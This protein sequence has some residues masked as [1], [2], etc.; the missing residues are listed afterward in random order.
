MNPKIAATLILVCV[1]SFACQHD[2]AKE[3]PSYSIEQFQST[4]SIFGS[5][6]SADERSILFT[7]NTSGV[8][9]A[10]RIDV[11]TGQTQ[12]LT[13]STSDRIYAIS[14]F[15]NDNRMLFQSDHGGNENWHLFVR[16]ENGDIQDVT[17]GDQLRALF[18]DWSYDGKSFFFGCNKRNPKFMDIYEMDITSM[19]PEMLY[20]NDAGYDFGAI[21]NNKE[22]IALTKTITRDN[23]D[24]Y[25]FN[26]LKGQ[27]Q[28]LTPHREEANY[29][30]AAFDPDS[31]FL[32]YRTNE[33]SEFLYLKR[34]EMATRQSEIVKQTNWDITLASVSHKGT[35]LVVGVNEDA[36]TKIEL[37][38]LS[39]NRQIE[40]PEFPNADITSILISKSERSMAFYLNGSRS[41][42][43][44]YL[45]DFQTN[46]YRRLT[47]SQNPEIDPENLVEAKIV[48]YP[49]FDGLE[50]PAILYKP[51]HI[52]DGA[53][54]PAVIWVHGGPGGQS[55]MGFNARMQYLANHGYVVLAVN[56]R[57]SSGYGKTFF[58]LDDL[59]HGEHDLN[60]CVWGKK[61]LISTGYVDANKVAIAGTSYGGYM[62]AAALA[63]LPEEF[64]AGVDIFGVTNWV[65]TLKSIPPW[66]EA[67]R[68]ALY[69]EMGNPAT[70]EDY[71]RRISPLFHADKITKPLIVLQ[72]ANDRR[73]LQTES[74]EIVEA[75]RKNGVPVEYFVFEDEGHGFRNKQNQNKAWKS[76]LNFL[77]EHV[78][79]KSAE[80]M[81]S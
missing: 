13:H 58:Q 3:V 46:N 28:H 34:Y 7:S 1:A 36:K 65:R 15:P 76:I 6:F 55:R 59:K 74:D 22:Y 8:F 2:G 47:N 48:R 30:P 81:Q 63:F 5:S 27:T 79:G 11:E 43:D 37:Y 19:T 51:H 77:D 60:D 64:A 67:F 18:Y 38:D 21:S 71:L 69:R 80:S 39:R 20:Q 4:N 70:D 50:I 49:S 66:W 24:I 33:N 45:Y 17:P 14:F 25:L 73:V 23:S 68:I 44:L 26:T 53:K 32:Y 57:G 61:Y 42:N 41:P 29:F 62:V 16:H 56:N 40:L 10:H 9:N 75:V 12:Q 72:G 78:K 35:Y 31:K 54:A 52:Q